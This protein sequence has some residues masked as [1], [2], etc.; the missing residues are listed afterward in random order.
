MRL[1]PTARLRPH[2]RSL[3]AGTL[4][5]AVTSALAQAIPWVVKHAIDALGRGAG[6]PVLRLC[7]WI[8]ALAAAQAAIR[9]FSRVLVFNIG[10]QVEYD[11][12]NELFAKLLSLPPS[13]YRRHSTGDLMSRLTNDLAS[14]RAMF[15]PGLLYVAN[16]LFAFA[17]AV[18]F[19][20]RIDPLLTGLALTP[21]PFL[22]VAAQR[23]ALR[24][25]HV[26]REVQDELGAMAATLQ[27]DLAGQ[28]VVKAYVLEERRG[29]AFAARCEAYFDRSMQLARARGLMQP[30]MG[31]TG[32][33]GMLFALVV[34]G[35]AVVRGRIT[36][37][38]LVAF[39]LYMGILT[40][41][42]LAV[43]WIL[44]L[45]QRGL[46]AW[47][48][49]AEILAETP[50]I[51][52]APG[53]RDGPPLRG[54]VELCD[55]SVSI[56]G[57]PILD[58][59]SLRVPEGTVLGLV[60]RIGSGKSTLCETIPRLAEVPPGTVFVGGE[61]VTRV[62]LARL[63]R[64]VGY[65]PQ[66]AFLFSTSIRRNIEMGGAA[67]GRPAAACAGAAGLDPDLAALPDGIETVVG[68][69]G[70]TLSGGQRQRTALA[71]ALAGAPPLLVLDDSLSSVD[72]VTEREVLARLRTFVRGDGTGGRTAIIVSHRV[73]ALRGVD[74]IAV[75]DGGRV[76][77]DGTHAQLLAR[78]G[79]YAD[80]YARQS[81]AEELES[82]A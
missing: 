3:V 19:M 44:S 74:R 71:R 55:L 43:G 8:A 52:D 53:A 81:A 72:V 20:L 79:H 51:A 67:E 32:G 48:R 69:R 39:N 82:I 47:D 25:H 14:V 9:I 33:V 18:P 36:L 15:G 31:I 13:F 34:G 38:D 50:T 70:I 26:S 17:L 16:S 58:R 65:A 68:E 63:R 57:R 29:R 27:E 23:L 6:A 59:V 40:W 73:T 66:E 62:P 45:W 64:S 24:I 30:L 21:Y 42:T 54:D 77:E 1:L 75:L 56:G 60:G 35:W 5:L 78:G 61:D 28:T 76:V 22:F 46:A 49:L 11:L 12:R 4:C 2:L 41:P 37:G 10:R 7:G 80:L